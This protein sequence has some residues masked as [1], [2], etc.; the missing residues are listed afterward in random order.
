MPNFT[1][2]QHVIITTPL[3]SLLLAIISFVFFF[4]SLEKQRQ[5]ENHLNLKGD[6]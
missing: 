5:T 6:H 2:S 1:I 3:K 4:I